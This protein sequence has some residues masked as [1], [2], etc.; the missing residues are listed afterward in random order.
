MASGVVIRKWINLA[1]PRRAMVMATRETARQ[2]GRIAKEE[3]KRQVPPPQV[4]K[5]PGY[6]ATGR[7]KSAIVAQEPVQRARGGWEV[8]VGIQHTRKAAVYA[9]IHEVGGVIRPRKAKVLRFVINGQVIFAQRVRIRRKRW[10][11]T[12]WKQAQER[13]RRDLAR[14]FQRE[15]RIRS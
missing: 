14:H 7:L 10:F 4:G 2:A 11:A 5:W 12:G 15:I 8:R 6:A 3:I 9:R 13:I 1:K